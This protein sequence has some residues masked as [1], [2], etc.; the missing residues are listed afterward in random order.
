[1]DYL[2]LRSLGL[3]L[4]TFV[5]DLMDTLNRNAKRPGTRLAI[6]SP[7]LYRARIS[8]FLPSFGGVLSVRGVLGVM[9]S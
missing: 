2:P 5:Q 3:L 7:A 9:L 4:A 1:M 8:A 6:V